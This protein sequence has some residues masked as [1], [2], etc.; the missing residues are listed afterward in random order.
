MSRLE[1]ELR[2]SLKREEPRAGF[3]ERVM[4][5]IAAEREPETFW[6][7]FTSWFN[8]APLARAG[9]AAALCLT[10]VLGVQYEHQRQERE[11]G[12]AAKRQLLIA[13]RVTG[14][15]LRAVRDKVREAGI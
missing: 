15:Q 9:L 13:L 5:R 1:D 2:Q 14:S 6:A 3:A 11:R 10:A 8:A 4:A 12:E 7:R